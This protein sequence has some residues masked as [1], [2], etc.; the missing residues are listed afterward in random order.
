[1]ADS[2]SQRCDLL[3]QLAEEFAAHYRRGQRPS[4]Q[5]YLD[6]YTVSP[7]RRVSAASRKGQVGINP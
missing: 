1:M 5:E 4:L 2:G 7:M 3:D 6:R